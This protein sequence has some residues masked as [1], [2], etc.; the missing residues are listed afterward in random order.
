MTDVR[1]EYPETEQRL[2]AAAGD[3]PAFASL[4]RATFD[5]RAQPGAG[6]LKVRAHTVTADH[7]SEGVP[8]RVEVRMGD[9]V[10]QFELELSGGQVVLGL[11]DPAWTVS[12]APA[13][14]V[15]DGATATAD[16]RRAAAR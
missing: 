10:R 5:G 1:L 7:R 9:E 12:I 16:S 15:E 6:E 14:G 8:A 11:T 13:T 4:G 2:R 3:V